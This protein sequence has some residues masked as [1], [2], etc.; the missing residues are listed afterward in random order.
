MR[1]DERRAAGENLIGSAARSGTETRSGWYERMG[2]QL[3]INPYPE[4]QRDTAR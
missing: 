2:E 4:G 1:I 3:K